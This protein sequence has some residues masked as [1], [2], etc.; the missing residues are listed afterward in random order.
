MLA[1]EV[2]TEKN[3]RRNVVARLLRAVS[4]TR[5]SDLSVGGPTRQSLVH[6]FD[7]YAELLSHASREPRCFLGHLARR[8]VEIQRM[9]HDNQ[10]CVPLARNGSKIPHYVAAVPPLENS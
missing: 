9:P 2:I 3:R 5:C 7:G 8:A 1:L 6:E 4:A 10:A